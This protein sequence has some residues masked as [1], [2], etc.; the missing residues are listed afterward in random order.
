MPQF[1]VKNRHDVGGAISKAAGDVAA[2]NP[3]GGKP[4][5]VSG[6]ASSDKSSRVPAVAGSLNYYMRKTMADGKGN[7][8]NRAYALWKRDRANRARGGR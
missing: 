3:N 1:D 7:A 4:R 8:R 6:A 5:V 2:K